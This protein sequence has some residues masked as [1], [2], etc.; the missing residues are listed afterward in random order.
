[1]SGHVRGKDPTGG[2]EQQTSRSSRQ[3]SA[4]SDGTRLGM[5][6]DCNCVD[7]LSEDVFDSAPA[8]DRTALQMLKPAGD[9][10]IIG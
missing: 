4:V 8:G 2:R 6:R 10:R 3:V 1:M 7:Q 5:R 9:V